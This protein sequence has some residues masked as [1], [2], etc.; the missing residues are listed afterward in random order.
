MVGVKF[1]IAVT[2]LGMLAYTWLRTP[3]RFGPADECAVMAR[4]PSP[5]CAS[6]PALPALAAAL[7]ARRPMDARAFVDTIGVNTHLFYADTSY[8][9]FAMVRRRLLELGVRHIRDGLDPGRTPVFFERVRVL[10]ADG[11]KSTLIAC[12]VEPGDLPWRTYVQDAKR[13]LRSSLDA[14]E[15]VNE[16][17]LVAAGTPWATRAKSCQREIHRQ[18]R[19]SSLGG[20]LEVPILGPALQVGATQRLGDISDRADAGAIHPYAGGMRPNR[21]GEHSFASQM[22]RVRRHQF[23]GARVPVYATETG[24]HDAMNTTDVHPPVS[25]RAIAIY[26][27]RLFL[28]HAKAQIKRTFAYELADERP[29]PALTNVELNF[30]LFESD[31]SIKP[32][33]ASLRNTIDLLDSPRPGPREALPYGLTNTA[34][35]DGEGPRGAVRDLLLQKADGSYWLALWQ[36]STVWNT[37]TRTEISNAGSRVRVTLPRRMDVRSYRPR[38]GRSASDRR[39]ARSFTTSV[40]DDVLLIRMSGPD[41]ARAD[42]RRTAAVRAKLSGATTG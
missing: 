30:G 22:A 14:L 7:A 11:I 23:D 40:G 20:P 33:G 3:P 10:A 36:D 21:A 37:E 1:A 8:G 38:S 35:P 39:T 24:Y 41:A 18:A 16:P 2:L 5:S 4:Q 9:D 26:M 17:D 6:A 42:G 19:R 27:P 25:Q 13:S 34:D 31:W 28:E 12:R 15:G 32:S 29:D